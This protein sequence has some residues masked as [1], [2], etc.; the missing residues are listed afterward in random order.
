MYSTKTTSVLPKVISG[1]LAAVLLLPMLVFTALPNTVF[2]YGSATNQGV[3]DFTA[4]AQRLTN[5]YQNIECKKQ[6]ALERLLNSILPG[7]SDYD[8]YQVTDGSGGM[9][10]NWLIAIGS[11]RYK[12]DLNVMDDDALEDLL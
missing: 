7:F 10:Q 11:V 3:A 4:S 5:A 8:N 2:G 9:N 12:Q 1:V 6:S